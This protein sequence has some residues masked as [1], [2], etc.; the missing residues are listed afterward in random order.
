MQV[1]CSEFMWVY[2]F[3]SSESLKGQLFEYFAENSVNQ[4]VSNFEE[5]CGIL[6]LYP[7]SS[8]EVS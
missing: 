2:G 1:I 7:F 5:R 8:L 3:E 6:W 4:K